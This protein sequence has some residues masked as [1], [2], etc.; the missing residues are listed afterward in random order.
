MSDTESDAPLTRES[1]LE[2]EPD[3][4]NGL[5]LAAEARDEKTVTVEIERRDQVVFRFR[6]HGV[7]QSTRER[8]WE[9]AT[10][11][12]RNRQFG[13]MKVREDT[14][15]TLYNGLLIYEAT[16]DEDRARLWDNDAAQRAVLKEGKDLNRHRRAAALIEA[17]L[18]AGEKE[19]VLAKIDEL[20]G[21]GKELEDTVG[22]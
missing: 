2:N 5:L 20:S 12:Q 17:C 22:K 6:V 16:T 3:L 1:I 8:C 18:N 10:T 7:A 21:F 11:Y 14:N 4:L 9:D 13:G 15:S 19:A